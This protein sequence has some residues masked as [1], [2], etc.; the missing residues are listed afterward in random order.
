MSTEE[1]QSQSISAVQNGDSFA[2][3]FDEFSMQTFQNQLIPA[4]LQMTKFA[5]RFVY[6]VNNEPQ[7][8][9]SQ[10]WIE[11]KLIEFMTQWTQ[12]EDQVSCN[13]KLTIKVA[14]GILWMRTWFRERFLFIKGNKEELKKVN[15]WI[16]KDTKKGL[17]LETID[18]LIAIGI[19]SFIPLI[20]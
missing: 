14:W 13:T 20:M 10:F 18:D 3:L 9:K 19:L 8:K 16:K 5:E 12:I 4:M 6:L 1:A 11:V 7:G 2:K 15:E 17:R